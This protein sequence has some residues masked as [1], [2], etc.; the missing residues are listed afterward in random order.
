MDILRSVHE[1]GFRS[2]L[3]MISR[4]ASSSMVTVVPASVLKDLFWNQ[5]LFGDMQFVFGN[6]AS[7]QYLHSVQQGFGN[8]AQ[9][10]GRC[11]KHY[12]G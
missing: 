6:I 12:I 9:C 3:L 4:M 2:M 5:K 11:D 8:G 1:R 10:I 7:L